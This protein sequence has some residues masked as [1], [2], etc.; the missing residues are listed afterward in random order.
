MIK[1]LPIR[2]MGFFNGLTYNLQG[3]WLGIRTPKLLALGLLRFVVVIL[4]TITLASLII[5]YH[6][7]IMS[8]IW[9]KPESHWI[10]WMW[11]ILSWFIS[12][13]LVALTAVVS[14]LISQVLFAVVIM[15]YMSRI[16]ERM[17]TGHENIVYNVS[18]LKQFSYL[19]KQEVPR[20]ILPIIFSLLLFILGWL[21]P[22]GPILSVVSSMMAIVFLAWDNTDL[23][24]ARRFKSFKDRFKL[25]VRSLPFHLGFGLLFLVPGANII[26]LCFAPV[27]GTLYYIEKYE[28]REVLQAPNGSRI[29]SDDLP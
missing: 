8:L 17:I 22:L 16:T 11:H 14:Y 27:G 19:I 29:R 24:P 15:D 18:V 9:T 12:L 25:L 21:T 13:C 7:E 20:S 1:K 10:I 28:H 23:T 26:F 4:I 6:N 2:E 3:L 5:I